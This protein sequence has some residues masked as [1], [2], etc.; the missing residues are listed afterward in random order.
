MEHAKIILARVYS[1]RG[2]RAC[3]RATLA[4][5][6]Q[7]VQGLLV[8]YMFPLLDIVWD[9][10]VRSRDPELFGSGEEAVRGICGMVSGIMKRET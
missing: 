9:E 5:V 10:S 7:L 4:K 1:S 6:Q 8:D 2:S 3:S